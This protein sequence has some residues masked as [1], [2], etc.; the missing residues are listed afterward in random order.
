[1]RDGSIGSSVAIHS[2]DQGIPVFSTSTGM[3]VECPR[4]KDSFVG[5]Y[6]DIVSVAQAIRLIF[7]STQRVII[8]TNATITVDA[9]GVP[10]SN[11]LVQ[12]SNENQL[13]GYTQ[14]LYA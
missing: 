11:Q 1:M 3:I 2:P 9:K 4:D 7:N 14:S 5:I 8:S 13:I 12:Y 6:L 10:Y